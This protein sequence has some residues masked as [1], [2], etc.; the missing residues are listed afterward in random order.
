V[1][2]VGEI[3]D[4]RGLRVSLGRHEDVDLLDA[5]SEGVRVI[6]GCDLEDA[7]PDV[8]RVRADEPLDVDAVDRR[9]SLEPPVG[10]DR[11]ETPKISEFRRS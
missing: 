1:W 6:R 9:S 4:D 7:P 11:G 10:I 3:A 8:G 5:A 2:G